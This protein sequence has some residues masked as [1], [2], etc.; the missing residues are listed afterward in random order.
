[1][2]QILEVDPEDPFNIKNS[3]GVIGTEDASLL[4]SSPVSSGAFYAYRV[5]MPIKSA[6]G[7]YKVVVT[8]FE[9]YPQGG[10]IWKAAYNPDGQGWSSWESVGGN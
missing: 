5:V 7:N 9:A 6:S 2:T 3:L 8:L 4:S 1:M 10:R